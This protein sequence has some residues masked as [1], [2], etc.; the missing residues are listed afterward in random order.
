MT[1]EQRLIELQQQPLGKR[2]WGY[3][4]LSG[5]GYMQSAMTLGGGTIAACVVMGSL[6]GYE[7]LWVQTAAIVF[8]VTLLSAVAKQTCHSGEGAYQVFW[9]R[10]HP[11]M[12]IVWGVSSLVAT[13]LWHIPQ[14]SLTANGVVALGEGIGLNLD[15]KVCRIGIGVVTLGLA[16]FIVYLYSAGARGLRIYEMAVKILVWLIVI[17]FAIVALSTGIE[18]KRLFLGLTGI[19]FM[20]DLFSGDGIDPRAIKPIVGGVAAAV[21]INMVFLYPYSLL[22]KNW[23]KHHKELA[24]FDL[25]SGM[26]VPFLIATTL[27]VVAVA[28]TVGPAEGKAGAAAIRDV[29]A[30]VPVL[31]PTL[32]GFVGS[33]SA[34]R[35]LAL[36]LVG[37]GMVA[38]GFSTIITHMLASGFTCCELF[39]VDYR[40]KAK[41]WFSLIPGVGMVGVFLK[42]PFWAAIT[43]SSL[44][45]VFMPVAIIGFILLMNMPS[46]MGS[47]TPR[48]GK[49]FLWN[50]V[51]AAY[52]VA[53]SVAGYFG[54]TKN[55]ED[56]RAYLYPPVE[57]AAVEAAPSD[58]TPS[59]TAAPE[60][61]AKAHTPI[62]VQRDL[63]H[64]TFQ[65]I[66]YAPDDSGESLWTERAAE[67]AFDAISSLERRI[68]VWRDD[69]QA[70]RINQLAAVKPIN[71]SQDLFDVI[72]LSRDLN[73]RTQGAFDISVGPLIELWGYYRKQEH[74]PTQAEVDEALAKTGMDKVVLKAED[75]SVAFTAPGMRLDFGGIAK[76]LAADQA[77]A[78]LRKHGITAALINGG[79]S[80]I[81]AIGAPP[82]EDGWPVKV[83][84][85][86]SGDR[87]IDEIVLKDESLSTSGC[88]GKY[89]EFDGVKYCHIFD[90]RTGW[91]APGAMSASAICVSATEADGLSTAFVVLGKEGTEQYCQ[92]HPE[93]RAIMVPSSNDD[94]ITPHHINFPAV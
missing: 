39:G 52:L 2:L 4:A 92:E 45:A 32:G 75:R 77:G 93:V 33:E 73:A 71:V 10:L 12:A 67:S 18:W 38:I 23:G 28:N 64:A 14:Y 3:V 20:Q 8:G 54:L 42:F 78:V 80:S 27:M 69:S 57:A 19:S 41:F 81:L 47:E 83:V 70:T 66:M 1:D 49:R 16:S 48:G 24:Y 40:S 29:Q 74:L 44:A 6:L 89:M 50:L 13:V 11:L 46:Y 87:V 5:P 79:S 65:I 22:N 94:T 61:V 17:A 51:L 15:P 82:G 72:A 58:T 86:D 59:E 60:P 76:G 85:P 9:H 35:G 26:V 56:L 91:P 7:L 62:I 88:Y 31:G 55:W 43:A 37:L 30:I 90:P 53:I 36:L 63:M 34:G 21:G 84:V 25:W 68:N